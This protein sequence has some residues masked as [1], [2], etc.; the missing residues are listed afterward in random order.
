M[1]GRS[2]DSGRMIAGKKAKE[3]EYNRAVKYG[4]PEKAVEAFRRKP[5][6]ISIKEER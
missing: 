3:A 5:Y 4:A 2:T 6:Q 1:R